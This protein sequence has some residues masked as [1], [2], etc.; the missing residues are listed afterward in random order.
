MNAAVSVKPPVNG[1]VLRWARESIG[2]GPE[3]AARKA[4]VSIDIYTKWEN[5]EAVP[6][7]PRL[8]KLANLF[9]RPLPVFFLP[10]IPQALPMPKDFRKPAA[11]IKQP[12]KEASLMAIRKARWFQS[13]AGELMS[14]LGLSIQLTKF[15]G[16][17]HM[18]METLCEVLMVP[19][20]DI[21]KNWRTN[22]VALKKWRMYLED[23]GIFV[24]QFPIPVKEARGFSLVQEGH[25]PVIVISSHDSPHGRIFTLFHEYCHILLE[26][27]GL[28]IPSETADHRLREKETFCDEFAGNLLVPTSELMKAIKNSPVSNVET[29]IHEL[30]KKFLV[31]QFV[32]LRRLYS[33]KEIDYKTYR[34]LFKELQKGVKEVKMAGGNFYKNQFA[35]KGKKYIGL[36]VEAESSGK[37]TLS[38]ALDYLGIKTRHYDQVVEMLYE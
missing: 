30:S 36:V 24:F 25:P 37:I 9:K 1:A 29:I 38:R 27:S 28:C 5:G 19:G 23:R 12:L 22:W 15:P 21:R 7:M 8:R 18:P 2:V 33:L 20:M 35:E 17:K 26:E 32:I 31:S 3:K 11:V 13:I 6:S 14:D 16:L 10:Y 4:D 34:A